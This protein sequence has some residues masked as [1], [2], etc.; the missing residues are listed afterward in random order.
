LTSTIGNGTSV[1]YVWDFGDGSATQTG[2]NA[3][4]TYPAAGSYTAIVTATNGQGSVSASTVVNITNDEP[5]AAAGAD[6]D[7][8]VGATVTLSGSASSDPDNHNPLT[9]LWQQTG[10]PA[11]TLSDATAAVP[12]FTAPG[13]STVLTFSLVVTDARGLADATPDVIV[14]TVSDIAITDL[15]E[16]ND[17]PTKLGGATAFTASVASGNAVTYSWSFGDGAEA[18]G[19]NATHVYTQTGTYT[20]TLTASNASS[21]QVIQFTVTVTPVFT[22]HVMLPLVLPTLAVVK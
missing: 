11:V 4:H 18:S 20:V 16:V 2:T 6:Q 10:G 17:S 3:S 15:S 7:V 8:A 12:T 14:V 19:V 5:V 21:A 22:F 1:T 13:V 9:Y